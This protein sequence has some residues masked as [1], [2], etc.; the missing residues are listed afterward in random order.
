MSWWFE[1]APRGF[2][3]AALLPLV[4]LLLLLLLLLVPLL[5]LLL[6]LLCG[7]F[8]IPLFSTKENRFMSTEIGSLSV[9]IRHI[10]S[11]QP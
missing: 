3:L 5:L 9:R 2:L 10:V 4:L 8:R 6:L 1:V 11:P 7:G